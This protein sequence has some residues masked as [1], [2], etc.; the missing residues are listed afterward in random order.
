M[1]TYINNEFVAEVCV[2]NV[3]HFIDKN[4]PEYCLIMQYIK[5]SACG[6]TAVIVHKP[7]DE[8]VYN[9]IP[10]SRAKQ[11]PEY[12]PESI[13]RDYEEACNISDLSPRASVTLLRR[14]I[15]GM[16]RDFWDIKKNRLVD[17]IDELSNHPKI[18]PEKRD[19]LQALREIGNIGAHPEKDDIDINISADEANEMIVLVDFFMNDWYIC[20]HN[21]EE[22]AKTI[23][24][25][26]SKKKMQRKGF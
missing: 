7:Y 15:Q 21:E 14:C 25:I 11:Y 17:E 2:G 5:C 4:A 16:I 10:K 26:S 24:E 23:K 19:A 12:I 13:R 20:R 9:I 1:S 6:K 8:S 3:P 18:T 22:N